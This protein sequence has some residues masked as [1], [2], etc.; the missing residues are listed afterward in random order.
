MF[1]TAVRETTL[2]GARRS[3]RPRMCALSGQ[4]VD[5]LRR[6]GAETVG[7]IGHTSVVRRAH[8]VRG[9]NQM[10]RSWWGNQEMTEVTQGVYAARQLAMDEVR[11]QASAA[12]ANDMVI[13]TLHA[14]RSITTSTRRGGYTQH[15]FIVSMHVLGTAIAL[16]AH[17]PHPG[18]ARRAG[19]VD[20]P[21]RLADHYSGEHLMST[22]DP[23]STEGLAE[24]AS[25]RL[26]MNARGLF[27]SDL[28][29]NEYLC[30]EKAG[31]EPVG[32]GRR[33]EHLPHRLSAVE[34]EGEP[35]DGR[36][37]PGDVLRARAGDDADG[38][39]GRSARRRRHRRGPPRHR[40]LR[41]GRGHGRVHR[42]RHRDQ[43]QG[44]QGPPRARTAARSPSDLS[45][46][47]LLDAD[48]DRQ[49]SG[50]AWSWA[51]ASTTSPIAG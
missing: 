25:E 50:R 21:R 23:T 47:G 31:F 39:G 26:Q 3:R 8:S 12:G 18:P 51:T 17:E 9:R 11:R 37:H 41:V 10:M 34:L 45:R 33:L 13:S 36:P 2:A 48:A 44:R 14:P 22:Y 42:D 38:G 6:I 30:V 4:D 49:A 28:S 15:F 27:T 19:D 46:S 43:A 35:G 29:V 16:G 32:P 40:A 24:H 1:G 20:Q 5:K 7:V